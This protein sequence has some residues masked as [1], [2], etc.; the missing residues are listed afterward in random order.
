MGFEFHQ[1]CSEIVNSGTDEAKHFQNKMAELGSNS[2]K[3][4]NADKIFRMMNL[5]HNRW[6]TKEECFV[7]LQWLQ[8]QLKSIG[9]PDVIIDMV[10]VN[11]DGK[12]NK[13]EFEN[14]G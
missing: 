9:D 8:Y 12:L 10:D 7:G 5:D 4:G 13:R 14:L 6:L 11:N 1:A 3:C 2:E